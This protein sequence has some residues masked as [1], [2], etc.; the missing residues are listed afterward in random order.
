MESKPGS[1]V[2]AEPS[3]VGR[4]RDLAL[5]VPGLLLLAWIGFSWGGY[6]WLS[7]RVQ[8][9]ANLAARAA[10][11]AP[12]R[13]DPGPAA[14]V[15]AR[16]ELSAPLIDIAAVREAG[17]VRVRVSF[18]LSDNPIFA[19]RGLTPLPSPVIVRAAEAPIAAVA[20]AAGRS[21][22]LQPALDGGR[23]SARTTAG[24]SE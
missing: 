8:A 7:G 22:G 6:F 23:P 10:A 12:L 18:D 13:A 3:R 21:E 15:A 11:G 5:L 24:R 2:A 14:R 19:V 4:W 16:R 20:A 1:P 17:L 9:A